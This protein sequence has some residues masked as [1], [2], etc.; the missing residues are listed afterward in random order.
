M[1]A[2]M[3]NMISKHLFDNKLS[4]DDLI[5]YL[6]RID[7]TQSLQ[8]T[9][10]NLSELTGQTHTF[11]HTSSNR[12]RG[13]F[14]LSSLLRNYDVQE[15]SPHLDTWMKIIIQILQSRDPAPVHKLTCHV[16]CQLIKMS[17]EIQT[18]R[19]AMQSYLP[20]LIPLVIAASPE[21]R[22]QSLA[23]LNA[24]ITHYGGT[25]GP[26]KSK[27]EEVV[28]QE[29]QCVPVTK[30]AVLSYC[31]LSCCGTSGNQKCKYT[32]GWG[33]RLS[34]LLSDLHGIIDLITT[35]DV[36]NTAVSLSDLDAEPLHADH[37]VTYFRTLMQCLQKMLRKAFSAPIKLPLEKILDFVDKVLSMDVSSVKSSSSKDSLLLGYLPIIHTDA[38]GIINVLYEGCRKLM[39]HYNKKIV[40][41]LSRELMWSHSSSSVTQT[42]PYRELRVAVYRTLKSMMMTTGCFLETLRE[43]D[44]VLQVLMTDCRPGEL[45]LKT[46]LKPSHTMGPTPA[47][48]MKTPDSSS[49]LRRPIGHPPGGDSV[50]TQG[51]L[52][53]LYWWIVAG[54]VKMKGKNYQ[55]VCDFVI[56]MLLSVYRNRYDPSVPY[57]DWS[58]RLHLLRVL[59]ACL[60]TPHTEGT[61]PL[62]CAITIFKMAEQDNNLQVSSF[63]MEA[64][65][66]CEILIH[67]RAV[68]LTTPRYVTQE[69]TS[70]SPML[71]TD[72]SKI[73]EDEPTEHLPKSREPEAETQ[74]PSN[75]VEEVG[76]EDAVVTGE[77]EADS[78]VE[79]EQR[80]E[81]EE[82][83]EGD[84]VTDLPTSL[85]EPPCQE[86]TD[87]QTDLQKQAESIVEDLPET[88]LSV[89]EGPVADSEATDHNLDPQTDSDCP[90]VRGEIEVNR[91]PAPSGS[92]DIDKAMEDSSQPKDNLAQS[93]SS[94][95]VKEINEP[96]DDDLKDMLMTFVDADPE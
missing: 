49:D 44:S 57:N 52:Q 90:N 2:T 58:C 83:G 56:T 17:N 21:W 6:K 53:A 15:L 46:S 92:S 16:C 70:S 31:L 73:S 95:F 48:K 13:L 82:D 24:C 66:L 87:P 65:R 33:A 62:Q 71:T 93:S 63:C 8:I 1:A 51:A 23:V 96:Q 81:E 42:R 38:I 64:Q 50:V 60:M 61:S 5:A 85:Q 35:D 7:D 9:K 59:Q 67:S 30:E 36:S 28:T 88:R 18:A 40:R 80:R 43:E 4:L 20:Q 3:K 91:S 94:S 12:L 54:G 14:I 75:D 78:D 34:H 79:M 27:I 26:F 41:V 10:L 37:S 11:L 22:R 25:C 45:T 68:C 86:A 89:A 76:N 39:L 32:E 77:N 69:R 47:K 84:R 74:L 29:L 19:K 72:F 55:K